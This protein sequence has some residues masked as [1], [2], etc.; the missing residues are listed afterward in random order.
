MGRAA[1]GRTKHL[2]LAV[3]NGRQEVVREDTEGGRAAAREAE[4]DLHGQR[5]SV[6]ELSSARP[7]AARGVG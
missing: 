3:G 7:D 6:R 2:T 4:R 5:L 1:A